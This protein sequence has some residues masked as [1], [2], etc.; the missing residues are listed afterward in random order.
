MSLKRTKVYWKHDCEPKSPSVFHVRKIIFVTGDG[1]SALETNAVLS[2]KSF[3]DNDTT[4]AMDEDIPRFG[5]I[6]FAFSI[7]VQP[8]FGGISC[9]DDLRGLIM[10]EDVNLY[11]FCFND[12]KRLPNRSHREFTALCKYPNT[13]HY[14]NQQR[15]FILLIT[16]FRNG[17]NM[18]R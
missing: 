6:Q 5:K 15:V 9:K 8:L 3:V 16:K 12:L 4:T 10:F 18:G 2:R 17:S 7:Q 11:E 13:K 14:Q 1:V